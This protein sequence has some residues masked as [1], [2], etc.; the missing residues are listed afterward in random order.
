MP[1]LIPTVTKNPHI[2][3]PSTWKDALGKP[4]TDRVIEQ[5]IREGRY[6]KELQLAQLARD[7]ANVV[8]GRTM[9]AKPCEVCKDGTLGNFMQFSYLPQAGYYCNSCREHYKH[10][11]AIA[12][13]AKRKWHDISAFD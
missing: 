13:A 3:F 10:E 9:L 4:L 7:K 1:T 8:N 2:R 5:Y 6:T 12:L 11:K